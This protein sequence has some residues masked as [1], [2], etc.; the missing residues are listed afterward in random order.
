MIFFVENRLEV[1]KVVCKEDLVWV[2]F[3]VGDNLEEDGVYSQL[4][5]LRGFN[6]RGYY[7]SIL[8]FKKKGFL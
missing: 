3:F 1:M 6:G 4:R 5:C 7:Q 2:S 8:I